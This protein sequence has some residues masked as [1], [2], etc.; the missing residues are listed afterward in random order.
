[1]KRACILLF[2]LVALLT[3]CSSS[4]FADD[5]YVYATTNM[6]WAEFYAGEIGED[7]A[8]LTVS[9]DAVSTATA[10][11]AT[12]F[13]GFNSYVSNDATTFTGVKDVQVRM[14]QAVY[15]SLADK[16][17]YTVNNGDPYEEYKELNADGSFGKMVTDTVSADVTVT[18]TGGKANHHGNYMLVINGFSY[19]DLGLSLG[20]SYDKFLGAKLETSDGSVYGLKPLH[21]LW[22][23]GDLA[24]QM[25]FCVEEF[26]EFNGTKISYAHTADLPG[27]TI[28]KITLMLKN[29]PDPVMSCD[30]YVKQWSDASVWANAT[31]FPS[32]NDITIPLVFENIPDDASY[33]IS[34]V[35]KVTGRH[36]TTPV[37]YYTYSDGVLTLTGG[38][39]AGTYTVT[40]SDEDY[41]DITA[42]IEVGNYFFA[43]TD[44]T[45]AEF[46][47]GE[48]GGT[49]ADLYADGLDAVSSPTARV[50]SRFT[51]LTSESEDVDGQTIT[52]ITGVKAVQVR[53]TEAVYNLLSDDERYDFADEI[54]AEYKPVNADGS[55]GKMV[56]EREVQNGASIALTTPGNWGHYVLK[57]SSIDVKVNS[58]DEYYYLGALVETSDGKIYGMRHN[59]NLWFNA[60]DLAF[61]ISEFVEH[62]GVS[63]RWKYTS[64]MEGKTI[65]KITYM[66]KDLPDVV[67]DCELFLKLIA[68]PSI[69]PVY[70]DGMHAVMAG[71]DVTV[72]LV[73]SDVPSGAIYTLSGVTF[74]T[75]K[76]RKPVSGCTF[77][78]G[79]LTI[80]G[81]VQE[82]A[83]MATFVTEKY[84][85]MSAII[86]VYTTDAT[87]K[88]ISADKNTA[89]LM[90]LLTP[91]GVSDAADEVLE[92]QKFANATEYAV[93]NENSSEV[94]TGADNMIEGSG[95]TFS[96]KLDG[97]PSG[98]RGI[99]GF[100]KTLE[101][102]PAKIEASEFASLSAK[103]L[104]LPEAAYGWRVPTGEQLKDMGLQVIGIYPDGV[105]RDISG[106]ISSG[107][108]AGEGSVIFS[109]G[110]VMIDREFTPSEE[111]KVY[112]LSDEG[113]GTMS[114]GAYNNEIKA[115]WYAVYTG[116][117]SGGNGNGDGDSKDGSSSGDEKSN[118]GS[119]PIA[120]NTVT[121]SKPAMTLTEKTQSTV[122]QAL[123]K[124]SSKVSEST[125][126]AELPSSAIQGYQ[127]VTSVDSSVVYLPVIV[128]TEAKIYVFGVSLDKFA[129]D[130]PIYWHSNAMDVN[131]GEFI[132][133]ADDEEATAFFDDSGN[134][135]STVPLNKHVNVAAYLEPDREYSPT[136]T[137]TASTDSGVPTASGGCNAVSSVI[138]MLTA[139]MIL[140][141]KT[142]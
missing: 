81:T 62:H 90:F 30:V 67:V 14:T 113:E 20:T 91:K 87:S 17:R 116:A 89:Q 115:T 95:F 41:V 112:A 121:P 107:L 93:I 58:G 130:A 45:W 108:Y 141:R 133:A 63:R 76:G 119:T 118:N 40:F 56:T 99:L 13:S 38:A 25:G 139:C 44:M 134:E 43:T 72:E 33:A 66:L 105:S 97:V 57:V 83:Y 131:T 46:Y 136:I 7:A 53:M 64:D 15:N 24:G 126:V 106:Y 51:Q 26:T 21:N 138:V 125:E 3:A 78:G 70:P 5:G 48:V 102:T 94:F 35:V 98:E 124:L 127:S 22:I 82:G 12:R 47:A 69:S 84:S 37:E 65:T 122:K 61:S 11:F 8:D 36:S 86:N 110:T 88:V 111:G 16:S 52:S 29:Q 104:A 96:V 71:T 6:T 68:S 114:D 135:T 60:G 19:D 85:D 27:K 28:K 73:S 4:A 137:T 42:T 18:L 55:F 75:G 39:D 109:Y 79:V 80:K 142:R 10:R 92:A 32:S 117:K 101:I 77:A 34:S 2:M 100:S 129:V 103:I 49:S 54:F 59:N 31:C 50:A 74:G 132:S 23:R 1:M 120:R 9:Y 140:R 123:G 128:V